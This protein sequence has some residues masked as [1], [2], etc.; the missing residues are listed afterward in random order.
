MD[1]MGVAEYFRKLAL[2]SE[3]LKENHFKVNAYKKAHSIILDLEKPI[4]QYDISSLKGIGKTI[5][6][7]INEILSTQKLSALDKRSNEV[8]N[9]TLHIIYNSNIP[10]RILRKLSDTFFDS[11]HWKMLSNN[12]LCKIY[13]SGKIKKAGVTVITIKKLESYLRKT[14]IL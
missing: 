8:D 3:Y 7:K 14:E 13:L 1:N 11:Y 6:S 2:I 9:Q 5:E 12:D 10:P 4:I